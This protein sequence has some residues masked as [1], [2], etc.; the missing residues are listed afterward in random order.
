[1]RITGI[2]RSDLRAYP[3]SRITAM[4]GI[5][6]S[7]KTKRSLEDLEKII[8]NYLAMLHLAYA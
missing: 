8:E 3:K 4:Y 1:M 5:L 7:D 6:S 2:I